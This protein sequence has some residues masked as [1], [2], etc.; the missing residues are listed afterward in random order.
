MYLFMLFLK[1]FIMYLYIL[2]QVA[3]RHSYVAACIFSLFR[4]LL[5]QQHLN[6]Q[7]LAFI[8]C[9]CVYLFHHGSMGCAFNVMWV[10]QVSAFF[11]VGFTVFSLFFMFQFSGRPRGHWQ[12]SGWTSC[13]RAPYGELSAH[14]SN[15]RGWAFISRRIRLAIDCWL[16]GWTPPACSVF[17]DTSAATSIVAF[18]KS[19]GSTVACT[20]TCSFTSWYDQL[21][22][23]GF[24][25][26]MQAGSATTF[27]GRTS[28]SKFAV[29][30]ISFSDM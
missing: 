11:A 1:I 30:Y 7:Q 5:P 28:A 29:W 10:F 21:I 16:M 2:A 17:R 22:A 4:Q 13:S 12:W 6:Q 18:G 20:G 25:I 24:T 26:K 15:S 3:L 19:T 8:F 9:F 14:S 27:Y 23:Y